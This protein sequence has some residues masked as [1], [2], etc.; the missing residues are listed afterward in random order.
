VKHLGVRPWSCQC[1]VS[2]ARSDL[3]TR[4]KRKCSQ[5]KESVGASFKYNFD[6]ASASSV[7][8]SVN[9]SSTIK[10]C[11]HSSD[12]NQPP[13]YQQAISD[14][15]PFTA[16]TNHRTDYPAQA[17]SFRA[18]LS[19]DTRVAP[20]RPDDLTEEADSFVPATTLR[21]F[22]LNCTGEEGLSSFVPAD[23]QEFYDLA[24]ENTNQREDENIPEI[25]SNVGTS[26]VP[27]VRFSDPSF[28][29]SDVPQSSPFYLN[30]SVWILAFL[31]Q[32]SQGFTI[33]HMGS[34]SAYLS[35]ATEVV[36]PVIP[37]FHVPTLRAT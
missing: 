31:C 36:C 24:R 11:D 3:L 8:T 30:P 33:P 15:A 1:G 34:L 21:Q 25:S 10:A 17:A 4:H 26:I 22:S 27:L 29:I 7:V 6:D 5:A 20:P 9:H 23:D 12:D 32:K 14:Q 13:T 37:M 19:R 2:Y 16:N 28:L 35:R 18:D